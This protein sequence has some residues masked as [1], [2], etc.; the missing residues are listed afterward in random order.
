MFFS[1]SIKPSKLC[2]PATVSSHAQRA[3]HA[4]PYNYV[5]KFLTRASFLGSRLRLGAAQIVLCQCLLKAYKY[6]RRSC[7]HIDVMVSVFT[8]ISCL[9]WYIS[10][11]WDNVIIHRSVAL[12]ACRTGVMPK[13]RQK[14]KWLF[15]RE[16]LHGNTPTL[17][18]AF[19]VTATP[20]WRT[21]EEHLLR[22]EAFRGL[23]KLTHH[24][25]TGFEVSLCH[26]HQLTSV[27]H[28]WLRFTK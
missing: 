24:W 3:W 15:W 4:Q 8:Q 17:T 22:T 16:R 18:M 12:G 28:K 25:G 10:S 20:S 7:L 9:G 23:K 21:A 5:Q 1:F 13:M 19:L 26:M 11:L 14:E 27:S 6:D 2:G